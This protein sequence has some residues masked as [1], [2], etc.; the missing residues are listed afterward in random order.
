MYLRD[1]DICF[2]IYD[3]SNRNSFINLSKWINNIISYNNENEY[4][5]FLI[6]NKI[7][8]E[9]KRQVTKEEGSNFAKEHNYIFQE[10]SAK[11]NEGFNELFYKKLFKKIKKKFNI[12]ELEELEEEEE[13][14][15]EEIKNE[16][17]KKI[18]EK[19]KCSLKE[20]N[21]IDAKIYCQECKIYMCNKCENIHSGLINNH[22]ILI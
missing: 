19:Q 7:D 4:I 5:V 18:F 21:E 22:H 6:G 1:S 20:H 12:E 2:L 14:E 9:D 16:D 8:E 13:E 3:I 10:I 11:T 15:E 17:L